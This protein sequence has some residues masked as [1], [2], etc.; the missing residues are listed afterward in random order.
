MLR[1]ITLTL[2]LFTALP[3]LLALGAW[4]YIATHQQHISTL[5]SNQLTKQLNTPVILQKA[6]LGF[7]PVPT[8]DFKDITVNTPNQ[9]LNISISRVHLQFSWH[10]LLKGN[11]ACSEFIIVC[12]DIYWEITDQAPTKNAT[13]K[14]TLPAQ[15]LATINAA[16]STPIDKIKLSNGTLHIIDRRLPAKA[17]AHR[18]WQLKQINATITAKAETN[19]KTE[20]NN[21]QVQL[22]GTLIQKD[23]TSAPFSLH[24]QIKH[25]LSKWS[26]TQIQLQA[27]I[28]NINS[29]IVHLPAKYHLGGAFNARLDL[30]GQISSGLNILADLTAITSNQQLTIGINAPLPIKS[31]G[32]STIMQSAD[33]QLHFRQ[34]KL[35][36]NK[37]LVTA[38]ACVVHLR[39]EPFLHAELHSNALKLAHIIPWLPQSIAQ[40]LPKGADH[41]LLQC[42]QLNIAGKINNL[43]IIEG[44][45]TLRHPQLDLSHKHLHA[46]G[47]VDININYSDQNHWNISADLTPCAIDL[48]GVIQKK[49]GEKGTL[50]ARLQQAK[51]Q[52]E[53]ANKPR[54]SQRGA[55]NKAQ[56]QLTN[57]ELHIPGYQV[58][59]SGE[60]NSG[61]D[62]GNYQ[63]NLNV[64]EYQLETIANKIPLLKQMELKGTIAA[65][66]QLQGQINQSPMG[67]GQIR[68]NDCAISP[69]FVIAPIHHINGIISLDGFSAQAQEL[70]V[71]LGDSNMKV[72]ASITDL[73][74]PIAELHAT[75]DGVIAKDLVFNSP[76]TLL[77]NL[78]GQIAIHA[79]GIDFIQIDVDLAQGTHAKVSG[80]LSFSPP[81]LELDINAPYANINEVIALWNDGE[82]KNAD[83]QQATAPLT[84][85]FIHI[86]THIDQGIISGFK[87]QNTRGFIHYGQERLRIDPIYFEAE[88]GFG[89]GT[90]LIADKQSPSILTIDGTVTNINADKVYRQILRHKGVVTGQ[91]NGYF[92]LQ[93]PIGN[94][95]ENNINSTFL[96]NAQG[97]F[98]LDIK[99]GVLRQF[100]IISKAFSLLNVTQLLTF[101]LPD[102]DKEGMPFRHVNGEISLNKGILSSKNLIV[103][104]PAMRLSVVGEYNL[105]GNNLDLI[106]GFKP[107]GTVDTVFTHIPVAGWLLTGKEQAVITSYF[108]ISGAVNDPNVRMLPGRFVSDT[109]FGIFKRTLQLPSTL[110]TDPKKLLMNRKD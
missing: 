54:E 11:V 19:T 35:F 91:L 82:S 48:A 37:L 107:L 65:S 95:M 83:D 57:G 75:G 42:Q 72:A 41:A 101:K 2:L 93:G 109:I 56:W 10:A 85:E 38:T 49:S 96:P 99:Q 104:S 31:L 58:L 34:L 66:Y 33:K 67:S 29:T 100:S 52:P 1:R 81:L 102:M 18:Q 106:M 60:Y 97:T 8:L 84:K 73:R 24:G 63:L 69:T 46:R 105:M 44:H 70:S 45:F 89:T 76:E 23:S 32:V 26:D 103:D 77:N 47:A 20:T 27:R 94:T 22:K 68:L 71:G 55:Q 50:H 92:T 79:Q 13:D 108:K 64:P 6:H 87:F 28:A 9:N 25:L 51:K 98:H 14:K 15:I 78:D 62:N 86:N 40:A 110:I 30:D 17:T 80:K 16:I 39:T 7:H 53:H 90:I 59:F 21:V 5:V 3:L 12:P 74:Q 4:A 43:D 36:Y 88:S 61:G